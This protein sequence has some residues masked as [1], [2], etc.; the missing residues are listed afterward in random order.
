MCGLIDID[1]LT[2]VCVDILMGARGVAVVRATERQVRI[3]ME[4]MDFPSELIL[5]AA[6]CPWGLLKFQESSDH[7]RDWFFLLDMF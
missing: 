5:P 1:Y 6:L 2:L 7:Y 4:S 3:L